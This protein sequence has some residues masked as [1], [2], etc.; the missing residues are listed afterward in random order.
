MTRFWISY[1]WPVRIGLF[2]GFTMTLLLMPS[3]FGDAYVS[4]SHTSYYQTDWNQFDVCPGCFQMRQRGHYY[5]HTETKMVLEEI[6]NWV[7]HVGTYGTVTDFEFRIN[8]PNTGRVESWPYWTEVAPGQQKVLVYY[9]DYAGDPAWYEKDLL[10]KT[11]GDF[12]CCPPQWFQSTEWA[13]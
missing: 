3:S 8:Q 1:T 13:S 7:Y 5:D 11:R 10:I 9:P 2:V 12:G 4:A 6:Q